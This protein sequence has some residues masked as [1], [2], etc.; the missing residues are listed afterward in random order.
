M[1][2][3]AER[4]RRIELLV[5]DVDGVLT[6]GGIIQATPDEGSPVPP[7]ECK[8]FHVRDGLGLRIWKEAGKQ[9][10]LISGR[11]SR[12]VEQRAAELGVLEV[13]Q[14]T[15]DKGTALRGMLERR[16][17]EA[18]RVAYVGDDIIDVPALRLCGLAVTVA[19]G[20]AEAIAAAHYVTQRPGG[21]GAVREVIER[22][23]RC[24]GRWP[25]RRDE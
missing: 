25:Q 21:R 18:Q 2:S 19:D 14:G 3:L 17:L 15:L 7:V 10:A 23:L 24:Q 11:V 13:I 6:A 9:A 8:V 4:C 1:L 20:C 5:L 12:V 16:G 22:I